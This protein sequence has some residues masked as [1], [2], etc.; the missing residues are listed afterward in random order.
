M[1]FQ[2][3]NFTNKY[4]SILELIKS[5]QYL[6]LAKIVVPP[7]NPLVGSSMICSSQLLPQ[8][9]SAQICANNAH[10]PHE[11][12]DSVVKLAFAIPRSKIVPRKH[13][14]EN[15]IHE[16]LHYNDFNI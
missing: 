15:A 12:P 13:R 9:L 14:L 5:E 16:T 10:P 3:V 11:I 2:P 4:S 6:S 8:S 1:S 7:E